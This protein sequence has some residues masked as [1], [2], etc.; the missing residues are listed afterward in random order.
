MR[1]VR[2]RDTNAELALRRH[3]HALGLRYRV[4]YRV[5]PGSRRRV[6][7]AFPGS[8][9][10]VFIDGC[11]WHQ[12]PEHGTRPAK[13][14]VWWEQKLK[15]NV[16]RDRATDFELGAAGW[17]VLRFW[18]HED[19]GSCALRVLEILTSRPKDQRPESSR[20]ADWALERALPPAR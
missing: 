17:R 2:R 1:S 15:A 4:D 8:K 11:F 19:P 6:D 5:L 16:E 10:A 18:E 20:V 3:L 13:N 9:V 14:S 7:V 12:C